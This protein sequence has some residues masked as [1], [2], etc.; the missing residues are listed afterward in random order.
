MQP[1][2]HVQGLKTHFFTDEGIYRSVDGVD[3]KVAQ[4]E[5]VGIVG[6]SGCGKSVSALSILRLIQT[7]G[8]VVEGRIDFQGRDLLKLSNS[9]MRKIRGNEIAMIFQEP[10]TS[11]NPVY[12][13]GNQMQEVLTLHSHLKK[14]EALARSIDLLRQVKIPRPE[15][16]VNEYPHQLS[17]GM[18]QRVMIAMALACNPKLLIADEPTTA[19]DVTVQAQILD[20]IRKLKK[21]HAST[22]ILITHDMGVVAEMCEWVIVMYAGKVVE[23]ADVR[24]LFKNPAHP[25]TIGLLHSIPSLDEEKEWL[26]CIPGNVPIPLAMPTGCRFAPRCSRA[27]AHCR[28]CDPDLLTVAANHKVRCHH[29]SAVQSGS[30][31]NHEQ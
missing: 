19:L 9:E 27:S 2:L 16:I 31:S 14:K 8:R 28:E 29:V 23:E 10:M 1:L 20:L 22:M 5:T 6:E 25:Y 21:D 11:L 30:E 24:T 26:D 12:T 3:I 4:G 17:G 7:P 13:I 15:A 18:R